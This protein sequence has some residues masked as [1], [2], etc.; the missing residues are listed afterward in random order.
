MRIPLRH[1]KASG[2]KDKIRYRRTVSWS[3]GSGPFF[4]GRI[5]CFA[6]RTIMNAVQFCGLAIQG[7]SAIIRMDFRMIMKGEKY[8]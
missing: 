8:S 3:K 1:W 4:A 6:R 5:V 2:A 7:K